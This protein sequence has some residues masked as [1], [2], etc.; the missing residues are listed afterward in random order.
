MTYYKEFSPHTTCTA[1]N[2]TSKSPPSSDQSG[3]ASVL[4]LVG[5][6]MVGVGVVMMITT[7]ICWVIMCK[8][9]NK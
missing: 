4:S 7:L 6:G 2:M 9:R 3:D 8:C 5:A 1:T